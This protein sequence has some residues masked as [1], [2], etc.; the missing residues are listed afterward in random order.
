MTVEITNINSCRKNLAGEISA[1]EFE[2][3]LEK[4]A[5]EYSRTVKVPGFRPGKVPTNIMLRRFEKEICDEAS[6][7]I[8]DRVWG[9][10][11][12][13]NNL[14]PLTQ[15]EITELVNKPGNSMKFTLSFEEL[16]QLE[17]KDY[18][19][20]EIK[21][22]SAEVKDEDLDRAI[23]G[24]LEQHSQFVPVEGAAKDGHFVLINIDGLVDGETAPFHDEDITLIVGHA[25]TAA[26]FSEHLRG[27]KVDDTLSFD[28]S[29]P[30][31]YN[32]KKLAGK[33]VAY[34]VLVKEIKER[35]SPELNDDFA[36]D[37]GFDSLEA[38]RARI[39]EDLTMEVGLNAEMKAREELLDAIIE[40][41]PQPPIDVPDCLVTEE[42]GE[43]TKRFLNNLAYQGFD[44]KKTAAVFDWKKIYGEQ[45]PNA[46]R[47]VRRMIF[48]EAIARQENLEVSEE[49]VSAE[50][51]KMASQSHK[52]TEVLRAEFEKSNRM[53]TLKQNLLYDKALDF[54]YN[55]ANIRVE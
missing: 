27:A 4:V 24:I 45:R 37:I 16:P 5:R 9:D 22:D 44:V 26:E 38:F 6:Q 14:K 28:V 21:K 19:G 52:S 34:K 17:V 11:I 51:D 30:D 18:K 1:E 53:D 7:R 36:R 47:Q 32:S 29:Y 55:N 12:D 3:E 23:D 48:L 46:E 50:L 20:V 25:Q 2:K 43:Y 31:D 10:A 49:D 33:R 42:L 54:I 15:P 8:M 35:Q 40:R 41:Q 39:R 13:A